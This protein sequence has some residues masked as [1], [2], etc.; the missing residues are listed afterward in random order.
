MYGNT[1]ELKRLKIVDIIKMMFYISLM[2]ISTN[3]LQYFLVQE[4]S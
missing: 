1:L 2:I 3:A 4:C